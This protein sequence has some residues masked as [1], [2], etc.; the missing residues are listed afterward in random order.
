MPAT[1]ARDGFELFPSIDR[2][3]LVRLDELTRAVQPDGRR[4]GLRDPQL[5]IGGLANAVDASGLHTLASELL[6]K[7]A[8]PV[9][10]ILFD[11]TSAANWL[12]PWHRDTTICVRERIDVDGF[13]P[14]SVKD[15]RVHVQPPL[16]VLRGMVTLRL[17]IDRADETNGALRLI[18]ASHRCERIDEDHADTETSLVCAEAGQVL[19]MRP[20]ALHASSKAT[21]ATRRRVLHIEYAP[22]PLPSPLEWG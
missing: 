22:G 9:R 21:V 4:G 6:G 18:P 7:T 1:L 13:G 12:V 16:D 15:G 19:A 11:K 5:K 17:H 3:S 2:S 10:W 20:L 8:L 14:W